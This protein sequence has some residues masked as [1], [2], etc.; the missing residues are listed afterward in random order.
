MLNPFSP[1]TTID[2]IANAYFT[3]KCSDS[4][5]NKG[6]QRLYD[7]HIQSYIGKMKASKVLEYH[8]DSIKTEIEKSQSPTI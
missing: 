5:W 3:K 4:K 6:R 7:L 1:D 2:F 8:I